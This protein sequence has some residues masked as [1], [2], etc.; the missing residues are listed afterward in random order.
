MKDLTGKQKGILLMCTSALLFSGMQIA[1]NLTASAVPLAEQIFFRNIVSLIISF[2]IIKKKSGSMFGEKKHQPL[3]FTRSIMGALGLVSLFYAASHG[4][5]AD[6]T[7]L[8][9]LSP[10]LI[11]LGAFIFLKEKIAKIQVPSLII[12]LAGAVFVVNPLFNSNLFPLFIAFLC[13]IFSSVSYTILAYFKNKVDP[14]TVV[15]HFSACCVVFSLPFLYN[16]FVVPSPK[17]FILLI[18]IGTFGGFGQFALTYAYRVAPASEVSVYNYSG[19]LFSAVLAYFILNESLSG[20]TVIGGALVIIAAFLVY[21]F[22]EVNK[23]V[24]P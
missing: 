24:M 20:S 15:M 9:K 6:I 18:V 11:T 2:V 7:I 22:T 17:I 23:E 19:V 5:Q 13:S 14:I 10:F 4:Y 8:S 3:L 21:R 16:N 1:I 12:A